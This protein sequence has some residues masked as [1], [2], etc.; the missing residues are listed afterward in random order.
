[1]DRDKNCLFTSDRLMEKKDDVRSPF[2]FKSFYKGR[3]E[4]IHI[5]KTPKGSVRDLGFQV[6]DSHFTCEETD[7]GI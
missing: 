5:A 3:I 1:M 4:Q 7:Q 2:F 6:L